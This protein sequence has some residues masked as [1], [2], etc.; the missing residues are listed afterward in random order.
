MRP[1]YETQE[2][3]D[4]ELSVVNALQLSGFTLYKLPISYRLDYIMFRDGKLL[5]FVEIKTRKHKHDK[6]PSLMIALSKVM[7]AKQLATATQ[8]KSVLMVK[9]DDGIFGINFQMPHVV[10][11]GGRS[12]RSDNSDIEPCAFYDIKHLKLIVSTH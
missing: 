9:Y 1:R 12:D 3:R 4:N 7:A 11:V 8:T 6:Y 2:D 5:G 10:S